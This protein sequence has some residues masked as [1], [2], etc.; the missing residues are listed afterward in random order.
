MNATVLYF[1][2]IMKQILIAWN[3]VEN[4]DGHLTWRN[5]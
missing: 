2:F 4:N 5:R 3:F 1:I